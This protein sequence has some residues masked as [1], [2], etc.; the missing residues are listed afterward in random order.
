MDLHFEEN[1]NKSSSYLFSSFFLSLVLNEIE[2]VNFFIRKLHVL[3]NQSNNSSRRDHPPYH[4]DCVHNPPR[5]ADWV[6]VSIP[7]GEES[8]D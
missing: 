3:V 1:I 6:L 7:N 5:D 8:N 2:D 4:S